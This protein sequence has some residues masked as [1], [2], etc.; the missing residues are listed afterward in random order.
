[1]KTAPDILGQAEPTLYWELQGS[2]QHP[3]GDW[4]GARGGSGQDVDA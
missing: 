4:G 1:M 3:L 2:Q